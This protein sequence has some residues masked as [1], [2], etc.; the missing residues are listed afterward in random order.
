M[1]NENHD[2]QFPIPTGATGYDF[3][4]ESPSLITDVSRDA[5]LG[6]Q[7]G[8]F[9]TEG[10]PMLLTVSGGKTIGVPIFTAVKV[11]VAQIRIDPRLTTRPNFGTN[12]EHK[13][14]KEF[15]QLCKS[16]LQCQGNVDPVVCSLSD[17][18]LTIL[19]ESVPYLD[20]RVGV[21]RYWAIVECELPEILVRVVPADM[22]VGE[23]LLL[24]L[25]QN[26]TQQQLAILDKCDAIATLIDVHHLK[27][28]IVAEK[29]G[30]N[31]STISRHY[32]AA[33][34]GV[35]I[36]SY[37]AN[38]SLSLDTV[39]LLI[40]RIKDSE[41]RETAAIYLV[42]EVMSGNKAAG[43]VE[44]ELCPTAF[45]PL[46]ELVRQDDDYVQRLEINTNGA[47]VPAPRTQAGS[48]KDDHYWTRGAPLKASP[49][50]LLN[51]NHQVSLQ[52]SLEQPEV[53]IATLKA[54]E[55]FTQCE[56][57]GD[58]TA[59]LEALEEAYLADLEAISSALTA[60]RKR[61]N[62]GGRGTVD[63]HVPRRMIA[64]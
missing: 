62:A 63:A 42:Q 18:D 55:F 48:T 20:L 16:I 3:T 17:D 10:G 32:N 5:T 21:R 28:K 7:D 35:R 15:R 40:E 13:Q 43:F 52:G 61:E 25:I 54:R 24:G 29:L 23:Q 36:R 26:E 45:S 47:M 50:R 1:S 39:T 31:Q 11:P 37:L 30:Y 4:S 27:Q 49:V 6:R 41:R 64:G 53:D 34:Q 2:I 22:N 51:F 46:V 59:Q 19:G 58:T 12:L 33:H 56:Q 8:T 9:F 38:G 14:D 44:N 60:M 57:Q